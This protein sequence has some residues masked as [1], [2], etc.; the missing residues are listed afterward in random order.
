MIAVFSLIMLGVMQIF[1]NEI[2]H[3]FVNEQQVIDLGG[4]ALKLTSWFYFF[5]GTIYITRGTL[6]G[7][8]DALF[9][10]INGSVEMAGRILLPLL[11]SLVLGVGVWGIW[12]T[13]GLT[14]GLSASFCL[15]R[16]FSWSKNHRKPGKI[17]R[18]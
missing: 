18:K 2:I 14:W 17:L 3:L 8:G 12:W 4:S 16:Y 1:G 7:I 15:I 13:A 9:S 10:L 5:L 6:N 11:M